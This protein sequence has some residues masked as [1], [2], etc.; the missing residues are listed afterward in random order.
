MR[1]TQSR[2]GLIDV[3]LLLVAAVWG[4][5]YLAVK[6]LV[7]PATVVAVLALRFVVTTVAMLPL[8]LRRLRGAGRG[9]LVTG[10]LL[11]LIL[12]VIFALETFGVAHTTATNAGLIISLTIV[13]TPL[14]ESAVSRSWLPARF[15]LA[16]VMAVVGVGLLASRSGLHAPTLGDW[17][18]LAA[19]AIRA[20]HVTVMHR[21]SAGKTYDSL[22]LTFIQLATAAALFCL[23][24][25]LVGGSAVSLATRIGPVQWADL[26]YL[27]LICTVFA[28]VVQ[29]WAVRSTSPSRVSLLLGTEP[30]WALLVGVLLGGDH[31]GLYG[32]IGAVL[33][34]V[35]AGWGQRIER[36]HR[37]GRQGRPP[38]ESAA[39]EEQ[40]AAQP[41]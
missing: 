26:L 2:A 6:E 9:E 18:I 12:A 1:E 31:L 34:V 3:L 30:V 16:T 32:A 28:F 21:R 4:S 22:N 25:P 14:L 13:M 20:V 33:I 37:E 10:T 40:T 38:A 24:G 17:L 8:A 35:G 19:A 23:A 39:P 27:A 41:A 15:F 11:G 5:T 7:T 29:T 36:R